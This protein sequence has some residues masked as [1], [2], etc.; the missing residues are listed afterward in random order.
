MAIRKARIKAPVKKL[1]AKLM[2]KDD[3]KRATTRMLKDLGIKSPW[4]LN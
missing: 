4:K 1:A 3:K 2:T